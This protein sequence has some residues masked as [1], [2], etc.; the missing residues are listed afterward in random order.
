MDKDNVINQS[1]FKKFRKALL[2]GFEY[3]DDKK[4]PG[5]PVD[6]YLVYCFL[7][8]NGWEDSEISILTDIV[9]DD[10]TDI[11]KASI[12]ENVVNSG[13]LTFIEE[14][15]E[16]NIYH[17][18]KF[19]N[20]Y[21]NFS[22]FFD[23]D[24]ENLFIY[25]SGHCKDG[26]IILPDK[27]LISLNHFRNLLMKNDVFL[28]MDC[29]EGG[30]ELPWVLSDDIYRLKDDITKETFISSK[31][32]CISSSLENENS[33]T[34]RSGSYF[35][36]TLFKLLKPDDLNNLLKSICSAL[37]SIKQTSNISSSFPNLSYIPA[38]VFS[39]A[40]ISIYATNTYIIV[41]TY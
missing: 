25:Y 41:K 27:A 17:C 34:S 36:R 1:S 28:I 24:V 5:I 2:I 14:I 22:T 21:N 9:K 18:Y 13:V 23:V 38:F 16:K 20:H 32:I 12:L 4:L 11:L 31:I 30:I 37:S 26:N 3:K 33:I 19:H 15:R 7:K 39:L 35:T 6:L 8:E 10:A 29:C 40:K